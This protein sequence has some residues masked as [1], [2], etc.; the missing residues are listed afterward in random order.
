MPNPDRVKNKK[1]LSI[2]S[3]IYN[4]SIQHAEAG[5]L[6]MFKPKTTQ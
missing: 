6:N 3:D 5:G 2:L 4:P 1:E